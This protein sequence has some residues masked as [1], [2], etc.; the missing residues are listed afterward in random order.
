[1]ATETHWRS[2]WVE[3]AGATIRVVK[4]EKYST[5][6]IEAGSGDPLILIHGIGGYAEAYARNVMNLAKDFHVY[7]IDAL[8]HGFSTKEPF[9][10]EQT[11]LRQAEA[12]VDL[13][14]A[15]GLKTAFIKGESMGSNIAFEFGLKFPDRARKLVLDTGA[16]FIKFNRTFQER[17]GGGT[18]LADLSREAVVNPQ[19][20][21]VRKRLEWLVTSPDRITDEMVDLRLKYYT[22]PEINASMQ[23]VNGITAPRQ[24]NPRYTEE[25]CARLTVPSMVFWTEHNPGSGPDVGEYFASLIPNA[26]YYCMADAA[27]WPMWEHPEEH[28]R[29]IT[30]F[31]KK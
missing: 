9:D 4:G 16:Y 2:I 23:R 11:T 1:M 8:Y 20:E 14:D 3:L 15:E 19:R 28:D 5:R 10:S 17:P 6:V 21:T 26:E 7:A 13:M 27:H 24:Q 31:L 18:A 30:A 25:D 29:V 12:I 22:D